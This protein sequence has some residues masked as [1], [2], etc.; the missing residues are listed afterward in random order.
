MKKEVKI[1][2]YK[3]ILDAVN[4][5]INKFK[6][7][8]DGKNPSKLFV[9]SDSLYYLRVCGYDRYF[10]HE[11]MKETFMNLKIYIV[12][13]TFPLAKEDREMIIEVL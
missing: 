10:V 8:N 12:S 11:D 13:E 6:T 4:L 3:A 1:R 7:Y 5:K 9:D 2:R